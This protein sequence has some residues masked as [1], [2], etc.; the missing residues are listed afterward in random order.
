M[1]VKK[2]KV[3]IKDLKTILDDFVKTGEAVK[4]GEKFKPVKE[5][6]IY[7]T[8]FEALRKALTPKR[9]ELLHII[10]T[11][12]PFSINELARVAKRD[13]KNIAEDVKYLEQIGLIEKKETDNRIT[14][15]INYD[16]I[17]L[18]IAV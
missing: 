2:I 7:F 16:R 8:S 12:K 14:P 17:A 1:R 13:V 18:E 15:I 9:L 4:R 10:K 5:P 3:G 6:E 11:K